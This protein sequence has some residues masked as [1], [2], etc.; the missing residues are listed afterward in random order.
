MTCLGVLLS[1]E[2]NSLFTVLYKIW[3]LCINQY[4]YSELHVIKEP[5]IR[6]VMKFT[7]FMKV[8]NP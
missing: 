3:C 4:C 5:N 1:G 6:A 7:V 8:S 2:S